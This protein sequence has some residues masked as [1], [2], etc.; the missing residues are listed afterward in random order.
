MLRKTK[1]NEKWGPLEYNVNLYMSQYVLHH[2]EK[3]RLHCL[4]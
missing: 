1:S 3:Y 4:L 2:L